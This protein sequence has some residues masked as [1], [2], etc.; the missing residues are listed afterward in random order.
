MKDPI[1]K[2]MMRGKFQYVSP[3][4]IKLKIQSNAYT[5]NSH[6]K[7][8]DDL[9]ELLRNCDWTFTEQRFTE[10]FG[11][12]NGMRLRALQHIE[13]GSY[14]LLHIKAS[15]NFQNLFSPEMRILV[16]VGSCA[17]SYK[18]KEKIKSHSTQRD[19]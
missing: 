4:V 7:I 8:G 5:N 17:P 2:E 14:N 12:R 16:I 1:P 6:W 9:I 3:E 13:G 18:L 15:C 19:S 10:A 11:K